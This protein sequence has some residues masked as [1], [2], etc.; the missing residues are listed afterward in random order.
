MEKST[1]QRLTTWAGFAV[2]AVLALGGSVGAVIADQQ[3]DKIVAC[4]DRA[5]TKLI[6]ALN[7]RTTYT[8]EVATRT[9]TLWKAQL[10][11]LVA[12]QDPDESKGEEAF[13]KYVNALAHYNEAQAKAAK[14]RRN[15]PFPT[16]D[17][18]ERCRAGVED[19]TPF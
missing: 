8:D 15:S 4:T 12:V 5:N 6:D 11:F 1:K 17:E 16:V 9:Q 7:D 2:C 14:S 19:S 13:K 3:S 10:E 18:V